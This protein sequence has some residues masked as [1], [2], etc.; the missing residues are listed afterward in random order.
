MCD[1]LL[2]LWTFKQGSRLQLF[3]T[4]SSLFRVWTL[5]RI[6]CRQLRCRQR[7][8]YHK[9]CPVA[10]PLPSIE[11]QLLAPSKTLSA[12]SVV[13]TSGSNKMPIATDPI[14]D[15]GCEPSAPPKNSARSAVGTY[16]SSEASAPSKNIRARSGTSASSEVSRVAGLSCAGSGASEQLATLTARSS[17]GKSACSKASGATGHASAHTESESAEFSSRSTGARSVC[18]KVVSAADSDSE[19]TVP[20]DLEEACSEANAH[21]DAEES[22]PEELELDNGNTP[23]QVAVKRAKPKP[24]AVRLQMPGT[25]RGACTLRKM[26]PFQ[27]VPCSGMKVPFNAPVSPKCPN[28]DVGTPSSQGSTTPDKLEE[29]PGTPITWRSP[30]KDLPCSPR[31][32]RTHAIQCGRSQANGLVA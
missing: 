10:E 26:A 27:K 8:P 19:A 21:S 22:V 6:Q 7:M 30:R 4:Q 2:G 32:A 9:K 13:C 1:L 18:N 12:C 24:P 3:P 31:S 29:Q 25:Q 11:S 14:P 16:T 5:L 17:G 15:N 23:R 28:R 20:E